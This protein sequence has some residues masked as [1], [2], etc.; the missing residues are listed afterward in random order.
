MSEVTIW[1]AALTPR[2]MQSFN[3]GVPANKI[4]P[5]SLLL[6]LPLTTQMGITDLGPRS[7]VFANT[8]CVPVSDHPTIIR[9]TGVKPWQ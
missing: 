2:E 6:Y 3:D 5:E 4:R 1:G 9:P 8:A 7:L